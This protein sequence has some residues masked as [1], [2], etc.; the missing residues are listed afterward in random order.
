[1]ERELFGTVDDKEVTHTG[2]NF[3]KYDNIP[4]DATGRDV[5]ESITEVS[6]HTSISTFYY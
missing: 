4:V 1:M 6:Y 3:D 2:I 5:P